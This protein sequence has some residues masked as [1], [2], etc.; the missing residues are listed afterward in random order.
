MTLP[1]I[2]TFI[3]SIYV[4]DDNLVFSYDFKDGTETLTL[5]EIEAVFGSDLSLV[6]PP[7]ESPEAKQF[8]GI[9]LFFFCRFPLLTRNAFNKL[10]HPFRTVLFHLICHMAVDVQSKG[11]SGMAKVVLYS[12]DI[13][14][15]LNRCNGI[16]MS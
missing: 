16:T 15:T 14:A 13:I 7:K 6:A 11:G 9:F 12:F 2:D 8:Q 3:N 5:K 1:I 10:L 4:F